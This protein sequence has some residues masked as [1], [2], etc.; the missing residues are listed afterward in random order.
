[1]LF[2]HLPASRRLFCLS[3]Q[4]KIGLWKSIVGRIEKEVD[5]DKENM[6]EGWAFSSRQKSNYSPNHYWALG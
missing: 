3:S 2:C 5:E 6:I 4:F 1:M